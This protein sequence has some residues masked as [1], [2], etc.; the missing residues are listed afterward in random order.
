MVSM[1]KRILVFLVV[2]AI[3]IV[4]ISSGAV[5][6]FLTN[7]S[8]E[9]NNLQKYS[10]SYENLRTIELCKNQDCSIAPSGFTDLKYNTNNVQ[11]QKVV[12]KINEETT[13]YYENDINSDMSSNSCQ[14]YVDMY[15]Y[16]FA[17]YTQYFIYETNKY[18]NISLYRTIADLC[19]DAVSYT[20]V[21]TYFFDKVTQQWLSQE[22]FKEKF[23]IT[24]DF[25]KQ[26]IT[27]NI[28]NLNYDN[29]LNLNYNNVDMEKTNVFFD[30][31]GNI[32]VAYFQKE[33]NTYYTTFIK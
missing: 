5:L 19:N 27:D 16:Q 24:D 14:N 10:Y 9:K 21:Q 25:I 20:P 17:T 12:K 6:N 4:L 26:A 1:K 3:A 13:Q 31:N 33:N 7:K 15:N 8:Q 30:K 23:N 2:I 28:N 29:S 22:E 11:I 18:T 32:V